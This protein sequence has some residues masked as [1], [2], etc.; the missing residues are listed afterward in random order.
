VIDRIVPLWVTLSFLRIGY[1]GI[2]SVNFFKTE[3]KKSHPKEG[4]FT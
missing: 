3:H 1:R 2:S 4:A